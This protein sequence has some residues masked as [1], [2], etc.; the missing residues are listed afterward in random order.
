MGRALEAVLVLE[1]HLVAEVLELALAVADAG[2]ALLVVVREDQL[3]RALP[4]REGLGRVREDLHAL[5][6]RLRAGGGEGVAARTDDLDHADAAGRDLVD[7][8]EVAESRNLH[9]GRMRGVEHG[10]A[11]RHLDGDS[12]DLDV[13]HIHF[14]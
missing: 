14:K 9:A 10:R 6:D 5:L 1:T 11:F 8:A 2:E 7:L 12:V 13:E 3:E 4:G